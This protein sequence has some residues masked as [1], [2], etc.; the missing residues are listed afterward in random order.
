M[1][2]SAASRIFRRTIGIACAIVLLSVAQAKEEKT[3][4]APPVVHART[5]AAHEEDPPDKITVAIDP[6]DDSAKANIFTVDYLK[7]GLLPVQLIISN[8]GDQPIS[9]RYLKAELETGRKAK[10]EALTQS[11]IMER[12]FRH[13]EIRP[14]VQGPSPLPIPLPHKSKESDAQKAREELDRARFN[15][16]AIEPHTTRAGFMFFDSALVSDAVTGSYIY[17]SGVRNAQGQELLYFE[18]SV[19]KAKSPPSPPSNSEAG[20]GK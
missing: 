17:V 1:V 3:Y 6:Y 8:D 14:H 7:Y 4:V 11:E 5:Y 10:L 13:G 15:F 12:L 9:V 20:P 2:T 16:L 19:E 18:L